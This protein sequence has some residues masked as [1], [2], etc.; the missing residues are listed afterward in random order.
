MFSLFPFD[1]SIGAWCWKD[2]TPHNTGRTTPT[3]FVVG[4]ITPTNKV[5]PADTSI[6]HPFLHTYVVACFVFAFLCMV[7]G[8]GA[9]LSLG[10]ITPP[11]LGGSHQP[12]T[13]I[14][15]MHFYDS[16][17]MFLCILH[18]CV[19]QVLHAL[20]VMGRTARCRSN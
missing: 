9:M 1:V 8:S 19:M 2:Y 11:V 18:E 7:H 5:P 17:C 14:H 3:C 6:L 13:S 12:A 10:R 20:H 15:P 4:R 16:L